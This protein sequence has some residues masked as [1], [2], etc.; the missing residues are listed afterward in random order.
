MSG[1]DVAKRV[2]DLAFAVPGALVL[3]PLIGVLAVWVRADS[4]GPA[5]FRQ[6]RVGRFGAAFRIW[7]LRT[8]TVAQGPD[9]AQVTQAGDA[10]ITR[11][12]RV[13]RRYKLDELPQL[14]NV[15][16]GDMSLVGPRPE[17]PKFVAEYPPGVREII[18]SVRP[19]ITDLATLEFRDEEQLLA[20][21]ADPQAV[22]RLEVLPKKLALYEKYIRERSLLGDLRLILRTLGAVLRIS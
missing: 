11:C 22:Y 9:A 19:G 16:A 18:L 14:F 8:M 4:P 2:F 12:G 13:L 21:A 10:R 17:V 5:F 15:I 20:A 6:E 1:E 3:L 7:K